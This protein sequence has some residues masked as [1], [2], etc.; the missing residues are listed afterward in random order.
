[1]ST[2]K[3]TDSG[4][5]LQAQ[6]NFIKAEALH[7]ASTVEI[8]SEGEALSGRKLSNRP[9]LLEAFT[10]LNNGEADGL[11]VSKLDRLSRSVADFLSILSVSRK[12]NWAL[13]I[14]DLSIDTST[15]M[16]E[17][18]AIMAATIVQLE[19]DKI[20]ER[21]KE[22]LAVKRSQGVI[23]GR[24][25]VMNADLVQSIIELKASGLSYQGVAD[26]LNR[27]GVQTVRT[28]KWY[29]STIHSTLKRVA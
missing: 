24:P 20:S 26:T 5:G 15:P 10:Q 25:V 27:E 7:R 21:T 16:G 22:G 23:L 13:I 9:A 1:V 8:I 11:I 2:N 14:G 12:G 17:A 18:M 19:R 6:V 3:Q 28:G 29:A 4:A